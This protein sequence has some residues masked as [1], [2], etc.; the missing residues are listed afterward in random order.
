MTITI[1]SGSAQLSK[2]AGFELPG[3]I[4]PPT[5]IQS[6]PLD[7]F[8]STACAVQPEKTPSKLA[9]TARSA[10]RVTPGSVP[11]TRFRQ[12]QSPKVSAEKGEVTAV[13]QQPDYQPKEE[14]VLIDPTN[15]GD[16]YLKDINGNPALL[17][18]I[19]VLHETVGSASSAIGLFR[20][21][22]PRDDDQS[23]Y[24]S[25][26]RLD[27]T[28]VYL[29][30]PDKRAF[31]AGNSAFKGSN[32]L[33]LVRTNPT[34]AGSVNN[35]AYHI[36]LETPWDGNHNGYSH[37]GYT[38]AQY[39]SLA[40]LVAKTN[41][42]DDRITTHKAVDRSASRIDPRSFSYSKFQQLLKTYPKTSEITIR[43][44]EPGE[45]PQT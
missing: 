7:P 22:H 33:E 31:G 26:I 10:F 35:F 21:P 11:L 9:E 8:T 36:S 34:L 37:S 18:P 43:C 42:P 14:I 2:G 15:F 28:V 25:L 39:E 6:Q 13:G 24:H 4:S 17:D 29:V 5:T 38:Q 40:W 3:R 16:R 32:G 27:G 44:T 20:T 12:E 41:V 45:T 1:H 23:S 19:V 30:P